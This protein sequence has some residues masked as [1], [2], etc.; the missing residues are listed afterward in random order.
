M[1]VELYRRAVYFLQN[2]FSPEKMLF[3]LWGAL[4]IITIIILAKIA[5]VLGYILVDKIV[6]P[7][8]G[9]NGKIFFDPYRVE[10]LNA[11]LKNGLRYVVY[12]LA[13]TI[14]L[15]VLGYPVTTLI[16]GAGVVG[17]AVGFG[18]QN[19]VRDIITG[20]FILFENQFSVGD[21]VEVAGVEG[22]VKEIGLRTTRI[23]SFSGALHIIPNSKIEEVTNYI[24]DS[25][26][27]M[28]DVDVAYEENISRVIEVL[29][30]LMEEIRLEHSEI[31]E[32]PTVLGVQELGS[33]SVVIRILARTK[34]MEQWSIE[35]IL[36]KKI[37]ERF[38]REGIEIPYPRQVLISKKISEGGDLH[39]DED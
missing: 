37:K 36:K 3:I 17:L 29:K 5:L 18:A 12:F 24:T 9:K 30:V 20:F 32:G 4:K 11:L 2:F 33:S 7:V 25:I 15:S 14:I 27:V 8:N 21:H 34:P 16:A 22:I 23:Q 39:A 19:L 13:G 10:T 38:D 28:V 31:V 1:I 6:R 26:R 35:R